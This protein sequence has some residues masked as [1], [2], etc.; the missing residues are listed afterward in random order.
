MD[1]A[2]T[3][4]NEGSLYRLPRKRAVAGWIEDCI[5]REGYRCGEITFIFC[6]GEIHLDINR[7]YLG[8][9]FRTDVITFDYSDLGAGSVAGDIFVDPVTVRD[10]ARLYGARAREEM[11]RVLIHGVLH[12]CGYKDKTGAESSLMRAK[13]DEYLE[14][15]DF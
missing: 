12:L 2:V 14:L 15:V 11:L 1:K 4:H 8:H 5:R 10:N 13:E 3:F 9:D 6:S 7:R